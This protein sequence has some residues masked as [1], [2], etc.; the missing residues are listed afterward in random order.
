L[1]A[2][3]SFDVRLLIAGN[4]CAFIERCTVIA[5]NEEPYIE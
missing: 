1:R 4:N 2:S 3:Q 5:C